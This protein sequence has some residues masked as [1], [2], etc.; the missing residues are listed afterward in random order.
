MSI[1]PP[2]QGHLDIVTHER[3]RRRGGEPGDPRRAHREPPDIPRRAHLG[4]RLANPQD[5]DP[6]GARGAR[7]ELG[8]IVGEADQPDLPTLDDAALDELAERL[9]GFEAPVSSRRQA[10]H[11]C[12]DALQDE[13][14]RRYRDG[15]ADVESLLR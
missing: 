2:A 6:G 7:A 13:V 9:A 3:T 12:I 8:A 15:E 4:P 10:L 14:K 11:A 1:A 5:L